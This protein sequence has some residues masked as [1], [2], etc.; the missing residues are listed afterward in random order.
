M[1]Y[2]KQDWKTGDVVTS[3]KLNHMEDGI[4][5]GGNGGTPIINTTRT[6]GS[7]N[8]TVFT[9]DKTFAEVKAMLD[10]GQAPVVKCEYE[11]NGTY[12][13][14]V[15][16]YLVDTENE[17]YII[18]MMGRTEGEYYIVSVPAT[19]EDAYPVYTDT[20]LT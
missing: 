6:V 17:D 14:P 10:A 3:T 16:G 1:A 19:A 7:N 4:A 9:F 5:E 2:E 12:F 11:S 8:S 18:R 15:I 20:P 13:N